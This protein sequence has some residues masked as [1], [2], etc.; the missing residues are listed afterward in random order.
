MGQDKILEA[1][2]NLINPT[3]IP[4]QI[5]TNLEEVEKDVIGAELTREEMA[6]IFSTEDPL[7]QD[8]REFL[9]WRHRLNH[10]YFKSLFRLSNRGIIT[11]EISKFRKLPLCVACL[12]GNSHKSPWITKVKRSGRLI[13]KPLDARPVS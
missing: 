5:P 1:G 3:D 2:D 9:V 11:R 7:G 4:S 6:K 12:F 10:C 8:K 13:R